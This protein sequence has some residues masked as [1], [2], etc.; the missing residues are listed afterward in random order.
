[1]KDCGTKQTIG[2]ILQNSKEK[3]NGNTKYIY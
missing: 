3:C 1:M 2:K